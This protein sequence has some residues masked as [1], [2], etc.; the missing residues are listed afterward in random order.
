MPLRLSVIIPAYNEEQNLPRTLKKLV[1]FCHEVI[2]VDGHS[3]DATAKIASKMGAQVLLSQKG[4]GLQMALG[5]SKAKG[6][7]LCFVHADTL[8]P[9]DFARHISLAL[10]DSRVVWGAFALGVD[11]RTLGLNLIC[12]GA[13]L[14]TRLFKL[15]YGDQAIF[16][17]RDAYFAVGGFAPVPLMEDV[18]LARKLGRIGRFCFVRARVVTSARR[19]QQEGLLARTL[20]NYSLLLR[21]A[22]GDSPQSLAKKY[23]DSR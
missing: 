15:P 7:V 23:K 19:W 8:V 17:R 13:N 20:K 18:D 21:H 3:Q 12:L 4:R 16:V 2:V 5:A 6:D 10:K 1:G 11:A 9:K 14:R 22:F